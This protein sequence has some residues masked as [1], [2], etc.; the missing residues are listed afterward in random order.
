MLILKCASALLVVILL[1]SNPISAEA[2]SLSEKYIKKYFA[3]KKPAPKEATP[4]EPEKT[5]NYEIVQGHDKQ[6]K[7][8]SP[9]AIGKIKVNSTSPL[10]MPSNFT[11]RKINISNYSDYANFKA[12]ASPKWAEFAKINAIGIDIDCKF[13]VS[14]DSLKRFD[15]APPILG[16]LTEKGRVYGPMADNP[17]W[18]RN[19]NKTVIILDPPYKISQKAQ[20]IHIVAQM[21]AINYTVSK[22]SLTFYHTRYV[23][24]SCTSATITGSN[25][26]PILEDT[27]Q[28]LKSGCKDT[29]L[30]SK[31]VQ[32]LN[33][34]KINLASSAKY[35]ELKALHEA[36]ICTKTPGCK[37]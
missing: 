32:A 35:Q 20:M 3:D 34:T 25:L 33:H 8:L 7:A 28:Y 30:I 9:D 27:I 23:D 12:K 36:K 24:E 1:S 18:L 4:Q 6:E 21:P 14:F 15:N 13:C 2:L 29:K 17:E 22:N 26:I 16:N 11:D 10:V 31:S 19:T 37:L 5:K